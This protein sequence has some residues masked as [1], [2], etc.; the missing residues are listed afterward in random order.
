MER[1]KLI[2]KIKKFPDTP[3]VYVMRGLH[4]EILYIG[5]ATSLRQRVLSYF[6]RPQEARIE[7]MLA[8]VRTIEIQ[9]TDSVV[10]ALLLENNLIKKL[11]PK[12]NIKL[13]DGKT[14][15]GIL[16]TKEDWPRVLPAR[17]NKTTPEGDFY[18]P[19]PSSKDVGDALQII[20]KLFPFR[21]SCI[22][23]SGKACFEYHLGMCPGVCF[24]K[25]TKEEYKETIKQIKLFLSGKKSK[26]FKL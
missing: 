26:R 3:G 10:E 13:K 19:F 9:R 24:G 11:E 5:K 21:V 15:L 6:Q 22:P 2:E 4:R 20:R 23:E 14:Y 25:V 1:Q 17:L 12:Y 16:V 8:N 7:L 18:G